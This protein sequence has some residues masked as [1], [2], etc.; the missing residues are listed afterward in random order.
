[1]K[2]LGHNIKILNLQVKI[3]ILT[4]IE[5]L[6]AMLSLLSSSFLTPDDFRNKHFST[7]YFGFQDLKICAQ[8]MEVVSNAYIVESL[9]HRLK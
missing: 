9:I 3:Y 7:V 1:M 5:N 6:Q 4:K 8:L 2:F